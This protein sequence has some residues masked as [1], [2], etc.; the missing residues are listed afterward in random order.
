MEFIT[1]FFKD[2]KERLSSPIFS[3]FAI[4]WLIINYK[5]PI[6][7]VFYKIDD[8]KKDGYKSYIDLIDKNNNV[9]NFFWLPVSAA[10]L[11]TFVYPIFK[12]ALLAFAAWIKSWGSKWVLSISKEGSISVIKYLTLK[13]KYQGLI[14]LFEQQTQ[15]E[16][17]YLEENSQLRL[18]KAA[19]TQKLN[20]AQ[21]EISLFKSYSD[22]SFLDGKWK[23]TSMNVSTEEKIDQT[24]MVV[25]INGNVQFLN[26][27]DDVVSFTTVTS[28]ITDMQYI[29]VI[30][31]SDE[32]KL[33][34]WRFRYNSNKKHLE[35]L[36]LLGS[37][38]K[39]DRIA[40][41]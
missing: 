25:F 40:E 4:A 32:G 22:K 34:L 18:E 15:S 13:D 7:I 33:I 2:L 5:I 38:I 28:I 8:L 26:N 1:D 19:I 29:F 9:I 3:S 21:E 20:E 14:N 24:A 37:V 17:S 23:Y 11:Y 39:L 30:M 31:E 16:N 35:G 10:I 6:G 41:I 12:N 27:D 36:D